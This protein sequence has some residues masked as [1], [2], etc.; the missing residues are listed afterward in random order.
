MIFLTS[1]FFDFFSIFQE[2]NIFSQTFAYFFSSKHNFS[3][4][5]LRAPQNSTCTFKKQYL[6]MTKIRE[7]H[8]QGDQNL[9]VQ[10]LMPCKNDFFDIY[11]FRIFFSRFFRKK[12][13]NIYLLL[14]AAFRASRATKQYLHIQEIVLA[15]DK[16]Q[17]DHTVGGSKNFV[18]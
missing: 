6:H 3:R 17:G 2:K 7:D 12:I 1:I 15:H 8:Q 11:F 16:N 13:F 14:N 9:F 5:A 18:H 10:V 4:G